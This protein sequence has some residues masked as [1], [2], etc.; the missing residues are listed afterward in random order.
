MNEKEEK[1]NVDRVQF[2]R[3]KKEKVFGD[4]NCNV[5]VDEPDDA[6]LEVSEISENKSQGPVLHQRVYHHLPKYYHKLLQ[7]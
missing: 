5:Q 6:A 1:L 4:A 7:I 3:Y 2:E